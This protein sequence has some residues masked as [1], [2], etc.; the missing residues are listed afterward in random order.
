MEIMIFALEI[1]DVAAIKPLL[2]SIP[3]S[4][5]LLAFGIGLVSV[6]VI[7]RWILGRNDEDKTKRKISE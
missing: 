7:L 3:E 4:F 1:L 2:V 6:A 5:S